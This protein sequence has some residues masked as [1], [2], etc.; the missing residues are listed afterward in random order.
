MRSASVASKVYEDTVCIV[1]NVS[2]DTGDALYLE[3]D[4]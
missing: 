3:L 4:W 1:V 2:E